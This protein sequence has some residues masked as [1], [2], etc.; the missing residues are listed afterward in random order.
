MVSYT[1][2]L[3][4]IEFKTLAMRGELE[5][6]LAL[7]PQ[8]GAGAGTGR[9]LVRGLRNKVECSRQPGSTVFVSQCDSCLEPVG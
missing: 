1:L 5:A 3:S 7:L 6:A 2:L 9:L 4:M 8:V